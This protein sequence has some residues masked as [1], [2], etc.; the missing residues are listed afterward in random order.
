M[1][2]DKNKMA[3]ITKKTRNLLLNLGFVLLLVTVTLVVLFGNHKE[4]NF[5]TILE[6]F[7]DSNPVWIV[8]AFACM[9]LFIVLEGI[10]LYLIERF[11]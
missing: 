1:R 8:A 5:K 7:K 10:S 3:K 6:Y 2:T 11:F 4:L 9:L